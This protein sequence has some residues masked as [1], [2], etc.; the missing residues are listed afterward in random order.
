MGDGASASARRQASA[1]MAMSPSFFSYRSASF[2][3]PPRRSGERRCFD[4]L[5]GDAHQGRRSR[6]SAS[7]DRRADGVGMHRIAP[8]RPGEHVEVLAVGGALP[9]RGHVDQK[10]GADQAP[11][12]RIAARAARRSAPTS[13]ASPAAL[14]AS[15]TSV[16]SSPS[17]SASTSAATA[18]SAIGAERQLRQ[19]ERAPRHRCALAIEAA[20]LVGPL[21]V[22]I[23]RSR[24]VAIEADRIRRRARAVETRSAP[25]DRRAPPA[26]RPARRTAAPRVRAAPCSSPA[27]RGKIGRDV[28]RRQ[29]FLGDGRGRR[30]TASSSRTAAWPQSLSLSASRRPSSTRIS[31]RLSRL[32]AVSSSTS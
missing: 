7:G 21:G 29:R 19:L 6:A 27:A 9:V 22:E 24:R 20:Q 8:L 10:I 18:S 15:T 30:R 32:D 25:R 3:Q 1:A 13:S 16:M 2:G 11:H 14:V 5:L 26:R 31:P 23:V 4:R 17:F 28:E 12:R